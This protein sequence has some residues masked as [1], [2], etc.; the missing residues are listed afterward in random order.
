[1]KSLK[2]SV[3]L[4]LCVL[5][6]GAMPSA[7]AQSYSFID[8]STLGG[9]MSG[10]YARSSAGTI[11]GWSYTANNKHHAASWDG[12][13]IT[14]LGTLGGTDSTAVNINKLGQVVGH[15]PEL[16]FAG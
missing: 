2:L 7:S 1:M 11:V 3:S 10:A 12:Q 9:F 8:L 5:A 4:A 16:L 6:G 13:A 14:D 15:R